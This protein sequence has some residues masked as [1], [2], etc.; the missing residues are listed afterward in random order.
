ML[1]NKKEYVKQ[2]LEN[3]YKDTNGNIICSQEL[4]LQ[5]ASIIAN[6]SQTDTIEVIQCKDCNVPHNKWLGC[7]KLNGLIPYPDF[8]CMHAVAKN[9]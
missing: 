5:I 7:P 8:W 6:A 9:K 2:M 1:I 3:A 4:W